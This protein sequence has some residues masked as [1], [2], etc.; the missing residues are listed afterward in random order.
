MSYVT[1]GGRYS[2]HRARFWNDQSTPSRP[3]T[4]PIPE[5]SELKL[6]RADEPWKDELET[7]PNLWSTRRKRF[8]NRERTRLPGTRPSQSS[9]THA[10]NFA[11]KFIFSSL[12]LQSPI[13]ITGWRKGILYT[14]IARLLCPHCQPF[15]PRLQS[16]RIQKQQWCRDDSRFRL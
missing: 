7:G 10:Q 4:E 2:S 11:D 16:E 1:K 9:T 14:T 3:R 5:I 8:W 15:S 6:L 13:G 12:L